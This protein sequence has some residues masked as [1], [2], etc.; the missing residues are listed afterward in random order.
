MQN[1]DRQY[2]DEELIASLKEDT[3]GLDLLYTQHRNYCLSYLNSLQ[4]QDENIDIYHDA[5]LVF[6]EKICRVENF[7][8]SCSIQTYLNSVARNMLRERLRKAGRFVDFDGEFEHD[9]IVDV[10]EPIDLENS[11]KMRAIYKALNSMKDAGGKCYEILLRCFYLKQR[12]DR[13]AYEMDYSNADNAKNQKARCQ[14]RLKILT[15]NV[16]F[17]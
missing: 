11:P 5:V 7:E 1:S 4:N 9:D 2:S 6:Y 13:I 8:L 3:N 14:K 16:L 15:S 10:L 12:M 17:S